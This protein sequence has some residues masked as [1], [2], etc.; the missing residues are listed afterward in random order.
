[1]KKEKKAKTTNKIA[2]HS[3]APH[4]GALNVSIKARIISGKNYPRYI[5]SE[6]FLFLEKTRVGY[7]L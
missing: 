3:K 6:K 7:I 4:R 2:T 5:S 1:M